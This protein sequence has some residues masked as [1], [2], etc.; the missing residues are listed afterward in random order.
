[1]STVIWTS[2]F[3]FKESIV[4]DKFEIPSVLKSSGKWISTFTGVFN[5]SAEL[6]IAARSEFADANFSVS[7]SSPNVIEIPI[8]PLDFISARSVLTVPISVNPGIVVVIVIGISGLLY[9]LAI[10]VYKS[11]KP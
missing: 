5:F 1:M 6:A 10:V 3:W 8:V 11:V 4:V 7:E 2:P 9:K